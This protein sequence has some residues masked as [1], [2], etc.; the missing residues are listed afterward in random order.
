MGL[1]DVTLMA[2]IG[3][4]IGWQPTLCAITIAPLT[5]LA[6]GSLVRVTT[7]RSFVAFGPYLAM[8]AVI[9]LGS[10]RWIWAEPLLMRDIFSHWPSV[11]GLVGGSLLALAVLLVLLRI[12]QATPADSIRR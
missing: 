9:C 5:A 12:F 11:A 3:A 1:G 4:F 6:V 7:G 2:M 8:S 10:W